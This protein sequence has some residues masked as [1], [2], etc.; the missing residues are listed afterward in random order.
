MLRRHFLMLTH[1]TDNFVLDNARLTAIAFNAP[2]RLF[3]ITDDGSSTTH[4]RQSGSGGAKKVDS[5]NADD[6]AQVLLAINGR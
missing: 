2:Q 3:E 6:V 1:Y 5:N 4:H